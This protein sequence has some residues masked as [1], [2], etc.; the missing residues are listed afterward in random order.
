MS[1]LSINLNN[2]RLLQKSHST[3]LTARR[4]PSEQFRQKSRTRDFMNEFFESNFERSRER[5]KKNSN[6][7]SKTARVHK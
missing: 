3:P 6:L 2:W 5:S 7:R 4:A 1:S